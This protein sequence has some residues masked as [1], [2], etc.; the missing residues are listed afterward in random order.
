MLKMKHSQLHDQIVMGPTLVELLHPHDVLVLDSVTKRVILV[1]NSQKHLG[2][3]RRKSHL[4]STVISFSRLT[5]LFCFF[6]THF[7]ANIFPVFFS[8]TMYTSEKAPLLNHA[9]TTPVKGGNG[10]YFNHKGCRSS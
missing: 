2:E 8:F 5:S 9:D 4:L 10:L 7:M 6:F 3:K 1:A